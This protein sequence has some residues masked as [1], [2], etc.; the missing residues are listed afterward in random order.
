M[1][2]RW[3]LISD[4]QY[5]RNPTLDQET[6]VQ[7]LQ[8]ALVS[9]RSSAMVPQGACGSGVCTCQPGY[10]G[11]YCEIPPSCS[12]VMDING[13]CC[14]TGVI[15]ESGVCCGKVNPSSTALV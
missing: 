11:M 4:N 3:Q 8:A 13:N 15:S 14:P 2:A 9:R 7:I 5:S 6:A 12:G 1:N 10:R